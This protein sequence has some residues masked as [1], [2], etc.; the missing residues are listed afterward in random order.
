MSGRILGSLSSLQL[1]SESL[2]SISLSEVSSTVIEEARTLFS[3]FKCVL[4]KRKGAK[5]ELKRSKTKESKGR[6]LVMLDSSADSFFM[7]LNV[8]KT[9][10]GLNKKQLW[11][12][13]FV[14]FNIH[15]AN[16]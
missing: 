1:P 7:S 9:S 11:F 10:T 13:F 16:S 14:F 15:L 4:E 6:K 8:K 2:N 3:F 5:K 12:F